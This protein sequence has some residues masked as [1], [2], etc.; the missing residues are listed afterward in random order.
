MIR[1]FA[2][3]CKTVFDKLTDEALFHKATGDFSHYGAR[4]PNCGAT[5]KLSPYGDYA[6]GLVSIGDGTIVECRVEPIRFKCSSCSTTHA[7]LPDILIPYSPYSL[8]FKLAVL[9]AYFERETTVAAICGRFGIAVST[10]YAWKERLHEHK[11]LLLGALASQKEP[12]LA[13]LCGLITSEDISGL[14]GGFFRRHAFSF[15]Q[16]RSAPAARSLPP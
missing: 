11:D 10:L 15:L 6:R 14:I 4:C 8:R 16:N 2:A 7:L 13:F 1:H 5:G 3:L 9:I 12:A